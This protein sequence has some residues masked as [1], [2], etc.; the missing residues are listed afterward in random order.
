M[1]TTGLSLSD[2]WLIIRKRGWILVITFVAILVSTIIH[3]NSIQPIYSAS[4]SVRIVERTS[5]S[6]L[7]MEMVVA[8]GA[9]LMASQAKVITSYPVIERVVL[10]LG[11]VPKDTSGEQ[12]ARAV[13]AV[14]NS[15]ATNQVETTNIIRITVVH[16]DPKKVALIA[17]KVA[18]V[19]IDYDAKEKSEQARK[20]RIFIETQ[21]ADIAKRLNEAEEKSADFKKSGKATGIAVNVMNNLASLQQKRAD[22]TRTFT[23]NY[24]DVIKIDED[25]KVLK[26]Q[27]KTFPEEELEFARLTREVEVNEKSYRTLKERLE[28]ARIAEAEKVE[29]VK[30]VNTAASP[31]Q[32]IKPNKKLN[33]TIGGLVGLVMGF[34]LSFVVESLDTSLGTIEEVEALLKLP[35][36]SVIPYLKS[37]EKKEKKLVFWGRKKIDPVSRLRSQL[38]FKFDTRSPST[39]A[40]RIL[41]TNLKVDEL[42]KKNEKIFVITSAGPNEGKSLT[43]INLAIALAQNG[44]RTLL[45]DGDFRKSIVHKVFGLK[46]EPGFSDLL[47]GSAKIDDSVRTVV[48]MMM[49]EM[50]ADEVSKAPGLDNLNLLTSGTLVPNP[51]EV[52][53][54]PRLEETMQSLKN[55][56]DFV[57]I[58]VPPI[59]PVPDAIIIA[60]KTD[61]VYLVYRS[62]QTSRVALLRAKN[63]MDSVKGGTKGVILNC[64]TPEAELMPSYYYYY[65]Y[66]YY[67][68]EKRGKSKKT[69]TSE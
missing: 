67:S 53:H 63:Q 29:D 6:S 61:G 43:A 55:L 25:I 66:K 19:Y 11:L 44:N 7:L 31:E 20:V 8:P 45:I 4:S 64:M 56:Y 1:P 68:E 36:L 39:E 57:I 9:D 2:Y 18:E 52:L 30:L 26:E 21:L 46:R 16:D 48:D 38:L 69:E 34:F 12:I 15:I 40:Y 37:R 59:L 24:P 42:L 5:V 41:R 54:S 60:L 35:V 23:E 50:G 27:L 51:A 49:G 28:E 33:I 62:G 17:N 13:A 58:D 10:E 65:H 3:T 32:P 22:L 14:Q 47:I